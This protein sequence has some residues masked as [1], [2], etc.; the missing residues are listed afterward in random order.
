MN[1]LML[2]KSLTTCLIIPICGLMVAVSLMIL[3]M[4]R[5]PV[6]VSFP[7]SQGWLGMSFCGVILMM[8]LLRSRMG[9]RDAEFFVR[10]LVPCNLFKEL[11]F[12]G[13]ILALQA[14]TPVFVGVDNKNF[15]NH[16]GN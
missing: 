13:F 10:F 4:F 3:L 6:L 1:I 16:V 15:V 8:Y 5:L 14:C 7:L 12:E 11:N 2:L 9:V